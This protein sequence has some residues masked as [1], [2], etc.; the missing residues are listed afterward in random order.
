MP[1]DHLTND[2]LSLLIVFVHATSELE[3]VVFEVLILR[4]VEHARD[5]WRRFFDFLCSDLGDMLDDWS[6]LFSDDLSKHRVT[7]DRLH[8][9]VWHASLIFQMVHIDF[10]VFLL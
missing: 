6:I 3:S 7:F 9:E 2:F 4:E 10:F 8:P 1:V 5:H